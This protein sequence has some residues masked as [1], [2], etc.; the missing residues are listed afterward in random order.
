MHKANPAS[1]PLHVG[2]INDFP[3]RFFRSPINDGRPDFPWTCLA[4]LV[5]AFGLS[6][7]LRNLSKEK[8]RNI[9]SEAMAIATNDGIETIIP[10]PDAQGFVLSM[11]RLLGIN[12]EQDY[13]FAGAAAFGKLVSEM[14]DKEV[15]AYSQAALDRW[16]E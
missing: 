3:V 9:S 12:A 8:V 13:K 16:K 1:V 11:I 14:S 2:Q 6:E 5:G 4:D 7:K 15:M 10:H